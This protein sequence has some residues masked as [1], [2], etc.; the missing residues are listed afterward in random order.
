[1]DTKENLS[2]N[3]V[4]QLCPQCGE[5]K[6]SSNKIKKYSFIDIFGSLVL[7]LFIL[8][9]LYVGMFGRYSIA[10]LFA[11]IYVIVKVL[12]KFIN[13]KIITKLSCKHCGYTQNK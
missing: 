8:G 1:M 3:E 5:D 11:V 10:I 12:P 13:Y 7:V 4:P 6:L 2:A 9:L